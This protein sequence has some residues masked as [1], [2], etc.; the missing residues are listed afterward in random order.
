MKK[1]MH[2]SLKEKVLAEIKTGSVSMRS[3][4]MI[5][6]R[7]ALILQIAGAAF[8]LSSF[9]VSFTLYS[10]LE[11]G[12]I[13]LLGFGWRGITTFLN[14]FPWTLLIFTSA[15]VIILLYL[16]QGFKRV[17]SIPL[18]YSFAGLLGASFITGLLLTSTPLHSE[19]AE[20]AQRMHIPVIDSWYAEVAAPQEEEG[21]FRGIVTAIE[22]KAFTLSHNDHDADADDGVRT[23]VLQQDVLGMGIRLGDFVY[24]AGEQEENIIYAYGVHVL[25][26]GMK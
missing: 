17:Y 8:V 12:E 14:L 21:E 25:S 2:T 26:S 15:S 23:V 24:V 16:V 13:F 22:G 4:N 5:L 11:S 1:H 3:R 6:L 20:Y 9:L 19:I 18:L 7:I 10:I